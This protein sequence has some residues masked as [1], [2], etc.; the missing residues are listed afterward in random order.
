VKVHVTLEHVELEG[1]DRPV[2]GVA[3]TCPRCQHKGESFGTHDRSVKRCLV[4]LREECP[5]GESNFYV[6]GAR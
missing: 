5:L 6:V 3:A 2:A 1:D 4:L